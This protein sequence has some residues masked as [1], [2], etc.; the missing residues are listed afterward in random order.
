MIVLMEFSCKPHRRSALTLVALCLVY[1]LQPGSYLLGNWDPGVYLGYGAAIAR[2][3]I[4]MAFN[5]PAADVLNVTQ[6]ALLYPE[7]QSVTIKVSGWY[8]PGPPFGELIPQFLPGYPMLLGLAYRAGGLPLALRMDAL[9]VAL[10]VVILARWAERCSGSAMAF[11]STVALLGLHPAMIWFARFHS[12]E[13]LA[14]LASTIWVTCLLHPSTSQANALPTRIGIYVSPWVMS[15]TTPSTWPL[16]LGSVLFAVASGQSLQRRF[17]LVLTALAAP[18][19][20][21]LTLNALD[22]P[23]VDHL[24]RVTPDLPT[25]VGIGIIVA[26]ALVLTAV[27]TARFVDSTHP[28]TA[29]SNAPAR[30]A[31]VL[32]ALTT[33]SALALP[34]AP[35][36]ADGL[37]VLTPLAL[38]IVAMPSFTSTN[39]YRRNQL[40]I[41]GVLIVAMTLYFALAPAMPA[42]YPWTWKRWI[43]WTLPLIS[44]AAAMTI[45]TRANRAEPT[46]LQRI[47]VPAATTAILL[48][49]PWLWSA[50]IATTTAWRGLPGWV[51]QLAAT[52]PREAIVLAD[53]ALV[54]PLEHLHGHTVIPLY[55]DD[56]ALRTPHYQHLLSGNPDRT[57]ALV[58]AGPIPDWW[59]T[60]LAQ[61]TDIAPYVGEWIKPQPKPYRF[62]VEPR[63]YG[64]VVQLLP[65]APTP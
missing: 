19:S 18:A 61:P 40:R 42:L 38:W 15:W 65:A 33:L 64:P 50:P 7:Q 37:L 4:Q 55:A 59:P 17:A 51:D 57:F 52:L 36:F 11:V 47:V 35:P 45:A 16:V 54:V 22:H 48:G 58:T 26:V 60:S 39:P 10:A 24:R 63:R 31:A 2:H 32:I 9:L 27:I 25:L 29:P 23:Y 28:R 1:L 20:V 49:L 30:T 43:W 12:A 6:T 46:Y 5:D 8:C 14:L 41:L 13:S 56:D 53:K 21:L 62:T 44:T 34:F 3:G